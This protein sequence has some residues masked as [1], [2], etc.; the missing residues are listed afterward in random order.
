MRHNLPTQWL[1]HLQDLKDKEDF[2]AYVLSASA[3]WER[4][5]TILEHKMPKSQELDYDKGSWA[6]YQADQNVYE[7]AL[8]E[9]LEL[10]PIDKN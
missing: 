10:L 4:L 1:A 5:A 7:R 8:K 3:L 6:Y 9:V 2:K